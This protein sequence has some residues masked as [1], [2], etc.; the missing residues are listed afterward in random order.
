[1]EEV[2]RA[3]E[4]PARTAEASGSAAVAT[5]AATTAPVESSRKRKQGSP[6]SGK[7]FLL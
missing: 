2:A 4:A 6:P 5:V 1:M 7:Q 3:T